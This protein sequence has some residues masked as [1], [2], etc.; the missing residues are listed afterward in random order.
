MFNL[1]HQIIRA[2]ILKAS[3]LA[4]PMSIWQVE[5]GTYKLSLFSNTLC[6]RMSGNTTL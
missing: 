6:E 1:I 4:R 2:V 3:S 5:S